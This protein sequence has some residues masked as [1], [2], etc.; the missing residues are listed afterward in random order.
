M[1]R[2]GQAVVVPVPQGG[3]ANYAR[4]VNAMLP[5]LQHATVWLR[6]PLQCTERVQTADSDEAAPQREVRPVEKHDA[7]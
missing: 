7:I 4:T 5:A 2:H 6:V 3:Y 1:A